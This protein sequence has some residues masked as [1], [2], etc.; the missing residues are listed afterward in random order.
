MNNTARVLRKWNIKRS[1]IIVAAFLI[2]CLNASMGSTQ[3][4]A[5]DDLAEGAQPIVVELQTVEWDGGNQDGASNYGTAANA[6]AA[7]DALEPAAAVEPAAGASNVTADGTDTS[8]NGTSTNTANEADATNL[9]GVSGVANAA[10][11]ASLKGT[12]EEATTLADSTLVQ[13][14]TVEGGSVYTISA[15][16][17]YVVRG[18]GNMAIVV[19]TTEEVRITLDS[20]TIDATGT[21]HSAIS[22]IKDA[23]VKL[24]VRGA[25]ALTGDVNH[26]GIHVAEGAELTIEGDDEACSLTA[27]GNAGIDYKT[28]AQG[29]EAGNYSAGSGIGGTKAKENTGSITINGHN[30]NLTVS[31]IGGGKHASG[32][33]ACGGNGGNITI[34][35]TNLVRVLGGC[36][37]AEVEGSVDYAKS[38]LEGGPAIGGGSKALELGII[39]INDCYGTDI[40]G[41]SKSAGIG[42]GCWTKGTTTV[43][44]KN[45]DLTV[46]GGL[47]GAAIGGGRMDNVSGSNVVPVQVTIEGS[48]IVARGGFY[49]AGVGMGMANNKMLGPSYITI[50]DSVVKAFGGAGAAGIG[51]GCRGYNVNVDIKDGSTI[52]AYAGGAYQSKYIVKWNGHADAV[53]S[54]AAGIGRGA[55]GSSNYHNTSGVA[56]D[57]AETEIKPRLSISAD[58]EV[59]AFSSGDNWA[60]AGFEDYEGVA[61]AILQARFSRNY[62]LTYGNGEFITRTIDEKNFEREVCFVD[63][64]TKLVLKIRDAND[65]NRTLFTIELPSLEELAEKYP[66]LYAHMGDKFDNNWDGG[67]TGTGR[68]GYYSVGFTVPGAGDYKIAT[69]SDLRT[70]DRKGDVGISSNEQGYKGGATHLLDTEREDVFHV[71]RGIN[72]FDQGAFRVDADTYNYSVEYYFQENGVYSQV[73]DSVDVRTSKDDGVMAAVRDS[74]REVVL[75]RYARAGQITSDADKVDFLSR[76]MLD[77][78]H[79]GAQ[80]EGVVAADG[81]LKLRLFFKPQFTVTYLDGVNGSVFASVLAESLDYGAATPLYAPPAREGYRFVGWDHQVTDTVTGD[82]VYVAQWEPISALDDPTPGS[83]PAS[84]EAIP[85][86]PT[87]LVATPTPAT[88]AP[89]APGAP[90][91]PAAF[92]GTIQDDANPLA[93]EPIAEA[94]ADDANPLAHG[95][96]L[97]CWVHWWMLLGMALTALYSSVVLFR[98]K[99]NSDK[100]QDLDDS[101]MGKSMPEDGA[102]SPSISVTGTQPVLGN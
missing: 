97:D 22:M 88:P 80:Y 45:S 42:G 19:N 2:A 67:G 41:G 72:N 7:D 70:M 65:S 43:N 50:S 10:S 78:D 60:F 75:E 20:A 94:I 47:T 44:I 87:P 25:N 64:Q 27:I 4:Y 46:L 24:F 26:A 82:A 62:D 86:N 12:S 34:N 48:T 31:A 71:E 14:A 23:V 76:Y 1:T 63:G 33:G 16:G 100:H 38:S 56:K 77:A 39:E 15:S 9:A 54:G 21:G 74:D 66:D 32:I 11:E 28:L 6:V 57:C 101:A 90:V 61:A 52:F 5:A 37:N 13:E 59:V 55:W 102:Q 29:K 17:D 81:S 3:A 58:S 69:S 49:G 93:A 95:H 36:Q 91:A 40:I 73:A 79:I 96:G 30:R 99:R 8:V 68:Y 89:A 18:S 98:R 85:D 53:Q 51:G 84:P 83:E 35:E 92:A